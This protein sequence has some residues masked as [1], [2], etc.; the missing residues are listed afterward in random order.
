MATNIDIYVERLTAHENRI[1]A[2]EEHQHIFARREIIQFVEN[3]ALLN[4]TLR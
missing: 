1:S 4:T 3:Y 2:I